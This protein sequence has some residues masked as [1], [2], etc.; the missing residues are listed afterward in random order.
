MEQ[1][2]FP[3]RIRR[4]PEEGGCKI[5][6]KKTRSGKKIVI[7]RSCTREQIRMLQ[8]SGEINLKERGEHAQT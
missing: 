3:P 5:E 7:S 8:E 2:R 4:R 1:R 6:V